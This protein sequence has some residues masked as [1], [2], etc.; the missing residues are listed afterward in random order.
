[1]SSPA[2]VPCAKLESAASILSRMPAAERLRFC[3]M[4]SCRRTMPNSSPAEFCDSVTPSEY[5]TSTSPGRSCV[6][7]SR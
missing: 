4:T 1:M 6:R 3:A 5:A 2:G 7:P